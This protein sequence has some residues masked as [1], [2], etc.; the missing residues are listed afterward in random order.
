M[1]EVAE[2]AEVIA[3]S[4]EGDISIDNPPEGVRKFTWVYTPGR[5]WRRMALTD[6][7]VEWR[8]GVSEVDL[9]C[10]APEAP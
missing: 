7:P 9:A 6:L 3:P 10:R 8:F 5:G 4:K 2:V 1:L